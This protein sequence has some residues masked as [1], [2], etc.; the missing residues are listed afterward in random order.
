MPGSLPFSKLVER[1]LLSSITTRGWC[2]GC[3]AYTPLRQRRC[4]VELPNILA[5][6]CSVNTDQDMEWWNPKRTP[7]SQ[8]DPSIFAKGNATKG[9][10]TNASAT[11]KTWLPMRIHIRARTHACTCTRTG[12][13]MHT[14]TR[15]SVH[16]YAR[17]V[18]NDG[19]QCVVSE[20]EMAELQDLGTSKT[21]AVFELMTD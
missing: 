21:A 20:G 19:S 15:S 12:A 9:N 6:G 10:A 17:Q 14:H 7:I 8:L 4:M 13:R 11:N 5:V 1:V 18:E 2:E 16:T 3:K